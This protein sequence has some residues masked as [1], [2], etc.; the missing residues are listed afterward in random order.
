MRKF[1]C[2]ILFFAAFSFA[3]VAGDFVGEVADSSHTGETFDYDTDHLM[4]KNFV[5]LG[6]DATF[7]SNHGDYNVKVSLGRRIASGLYLGA[8]LFRF[9]VSESWWSK[10]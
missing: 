9:P 4:P 1:V 2:L 8:D 7:G 3:D 10:S 5:T 6:V